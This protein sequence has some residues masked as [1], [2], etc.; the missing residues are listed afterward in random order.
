MEKAYIAKANR[1]LTVPEYIKQYGVK[2]DEEQ[3]RAR[4]AAV[5]RVCDT[6]MHTINENIPGRVQAWAHNPSV[7]W[8]P[9]KESAKT[10]YELLPP[11]KPDAVA[12]QLLRASFLRNWASHWMLVRGI[13]ARCDIKLLIDFVRNADRTKFWNHVGIQEWNLPYIFLSLYEFPPPKKT[14]AALGQPTWIRCYFDA[15][16]RGIR[17]LWIETDGDWDFFVVDYTPPKRGAPGPKHLI[18]ER[19]LPVDSEFLSSLS[20]TPHPF[21][22]A[23]M[24]KE[25][26]GEVP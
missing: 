21:A 3:P 16:V 19:M 25:F 6:P 22:V 14:A 26:P 10:P 13:V 1:A 20:G 7:K 2:R 12:G 24:A 15:R 17:D 11:T 9:L 18:R 5:C 4:P 23:A 8:C